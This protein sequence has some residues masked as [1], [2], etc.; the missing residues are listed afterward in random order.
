[1]HNTPVFIEV[2]GSPKVLQYHNVFEAF[3]NS[4]THTLTLN[5]L[6]NYVREG[7][8]AMMQELIVAL[9]HYPH[10]IERF[11][12]AI[13]FNFTEIEDSE[14]YFPE[15]YWKQEIDYYKWFFKMSNLPIV[16]FFIRDEDARFYCIAGDFLAEQDV[17]V[18]GG[19]DRAGR[20]E[21]TFN[22]EQSRVLANRVFN[23]CWFLLIYCHGSGFD[24]RSYIEAMIAVFDFEFTYEQ[25]YEAYKKDIEAGIQ[26]KSEPEK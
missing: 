14:I 10:L 9:Q 13:E 11:F 17:Q 3:E 15:S 2:P 4:D 18:K 26:L 1:M 7:A 21:V 24:P 6:E 22:A 23:A 5:V 8:V 20:A 16:Y 25:V 12:L 19:V